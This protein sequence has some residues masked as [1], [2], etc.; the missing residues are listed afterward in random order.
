MSSVTYQ[1]NMFKD[2]RRNMRDV[3]CVT[4]LY[5]RWARCLRFEKTYWFCAKYIFHV[6]NLQITFSLLPHFE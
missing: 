6:S 1:K 2:V 3:G 4:M 5:V